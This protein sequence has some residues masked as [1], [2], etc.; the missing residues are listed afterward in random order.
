MESMD[1]KFRYYL[2][3]SKMLAANLNFTK[4]T[5]VKEMLAIEI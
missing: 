3:T 1:S 2:C 5:R 4:N